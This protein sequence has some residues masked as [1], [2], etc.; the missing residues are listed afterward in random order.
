[1]VIKQDI[2]ALLVGIMSTMVGVGLA[3]FAY[4]PLLPELISQNLSLIHI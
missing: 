2:P 3:R 4:T 1:M